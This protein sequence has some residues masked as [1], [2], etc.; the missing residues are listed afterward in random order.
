LSANKLAPDFSDNINNCLHPDVVGKKIAITV[1]GQMNSNA[2]KIGDVELAN[3]AAGIAGK[4]A[5]TGYTWHHMD[6]FN[7]A[8]GKCTMQ[9]VKSTEHQKCIPHTGGVKQWE[10]FYGQTY[11][12][13]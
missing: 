8:T 5:P 9:L 12:R 11:L 1:T 2:T 10:N 13:N 6:D 3:Q 4:N 7:P